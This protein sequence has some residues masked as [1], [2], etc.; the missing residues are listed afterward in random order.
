M[1]L[2]LFLNHQKNIIDFIKNYLS[3]KEYPSTKKAALKQPFNYAQSAR[4]LLYLLINHT[5]F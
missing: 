3:T 5:I 4:I 1:L 2:I